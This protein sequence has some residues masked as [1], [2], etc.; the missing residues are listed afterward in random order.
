MPGRAVETGRWPFEP[1]TRGAPSVSRTPIIAAEVRDP[2]AVTAACRRIGLPGPTHGTARLTGG[3]D[4]GLPAGSRWLNGP[5][6]GDIDSP[7]QGAR[8][9]PPRGRAEL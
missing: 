3:E 7:R 8:V 5:S 1:A 2:L 6:F 4:A 9:V